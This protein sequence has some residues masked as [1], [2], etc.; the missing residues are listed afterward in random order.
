MIKFW[1]ASRPPVGGERERFDYEWGV[2]HPSLMA[3]TPSVMRAFQRYA[4]H[5]VAV[6]ATDDMLLLGAS[7]ENWYSISD[8]WLE[9]LDEL[10]D[11]IFAGADY[12]RRMGPHRFGDSAFVI[13]LTA[14]EV[15]HDQAVPFTGR[16][17]VKV[18]HFLRRREDVDRAE[19]ARR[20][21]EEHAPLLLQATTADRDLVRRYVQNPQLP[22]DPAVFTGTL[23]E[24]GGVGTYAGIEEI[25]FDDLDSLAALRRDDRLHKVLRDS[26]ASFV[27]I[28]NSFAMPVVERV[29]WDFTVPG[30]PRP[31]ILDPDSFESR[32]LATE[33]L[34]HEW[35]V[36]EPTRPA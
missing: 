14:G 23:F 3:M 13:E 27:D 6:G 33:R 2:M 15:L 28:E 34:A 25:W 36:V 4:Q 17:G 7:D 31:A 21:C 1:L 20:W 12:P 10:V 32:L 19:F 26:L 29:A 22:L 8:H 16:G 24:M 30:A 35:A 18:V 5:R 9:N 11:D